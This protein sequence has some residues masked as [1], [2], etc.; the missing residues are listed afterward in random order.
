MSIKGIHLI[1][2]YLLGIYGLDKY[3]ISLNFFLGIATGALLFV[4]IFEVI[5][6]EKSK[7]NVSGLLQ[8]GAILF[9]FIITVLIKIL[10]GDPKF[11][12]E[13]QSENDVTELTPP[14][15]VDKILG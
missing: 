15:V 2:E 12:E 3:E 13:S 9:G 6:Q 10:C 5:H 7:I 14:R 1:N 11:I 4:V 8:F